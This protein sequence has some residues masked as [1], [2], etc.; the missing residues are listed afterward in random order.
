MGTTFEAIECAAMTYIK[1]DL[2]LDWDSGESNDN[3]GTLSK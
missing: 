2:S 1:N 3:G